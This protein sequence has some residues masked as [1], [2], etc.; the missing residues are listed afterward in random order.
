MFRLGKSIREIASERNLAVSTIES[1]LHYFITT[2]DIAVEEMVDSEKIKLITAVMGDLQQTTLVKEKLG[3][4]VSY[5][6]IRA[7]MARKTFPD[8]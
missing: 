2:G 5:N 4:M 8:K 7:V 1:H 6:E 3:D